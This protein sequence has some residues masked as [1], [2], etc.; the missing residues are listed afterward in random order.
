MCSSLL[1]VKVTEGDL[2]AFELAL[3]LAQTGAACSARCPAADGLL[4]TMDALTLD[5]EDLAL[6]AEDLA[7]PI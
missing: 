6:A 2:A 4:A 5:E 3:E 7:P 1:Q